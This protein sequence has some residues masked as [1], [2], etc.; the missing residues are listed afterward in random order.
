MLRSSIVAYPKN[1]N[2]HKAYGE[3]R[4]KRASLREENKK[5]SGQDLVKIFRKLCSDLEKIM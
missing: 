2:T 4:E 1:L 5:I 3:F